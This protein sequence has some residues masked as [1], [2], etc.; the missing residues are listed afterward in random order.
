MVATHNPW[1]DEMA[2]KP[3]TAPAA[4][5]P[6]DKDKVTDA[7]V[8][9]PSVPSAT[10]QAPATG[11]PPDPFAEFYSE[12]DKNGDGVTDETTDTGSE[13]EKSV[14]GDVSTE[15]VNR[16]IE[17]SSNV[18]AELAV[19]KANESGVA[20]DDKMAGEAK[21][22]QAEALAVNN[23]NA[24]A[25]E[26]REEGATAEEDRPRDTTVGNPEVAGAESDVV[27]EPEPRDFE[28]RMRKMEAQYASFEGFVQQTG[29]TFRKM[30]DELNKLYDETR[31][32]SGD[33]TAMTRADLE[34]IVDERVAHLRAMMVDNDKV[35][36]IR[37]TG[38]REATEVAG[39]DPLSGKPY[40]SLR[41]PTL[42]GAIE[43]LPKVS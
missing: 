1:S 2:K 32:D 19:E 29:E 35:L 34:R 33:A 24:E 14:T 26:Q 12:S 43:D 11:V 7:N 22:Q 20:Y 18:Q 15:N 3:T 39:V 40:N 9:S 42:H 5:A 37:D 8:G 16:I 13:P 10:S 38:K 4:S 6:E 31:S 28:E 21:T 17:G 30:Q 36:R 25:A 41:Q 23:A 27:E